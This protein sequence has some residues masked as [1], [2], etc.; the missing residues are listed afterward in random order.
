MSAL[1]SDLTPPTPLSFLLTGLGKPFPRFSV[2]LLIRTFFCV[3]RVFVRRQPK[4]M[5]LSTIRIG[6][7]RCKLPHTAIM[8]V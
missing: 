1:P 7:V 6:P 5:D 4:M 2:S 3:Y 8:H